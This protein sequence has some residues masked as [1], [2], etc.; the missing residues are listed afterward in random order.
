VSARE[1]GEASGNRCDEAE[2]DRGFSG[3]GGGFLGWGIGARI[4]PANDRA[5]GGGKE[6]GADRNLRGFSI[7]CLGD[8]RGVSG[9]DEGGGEIS[10]EEV[11]WDGWDKGASGDGADDG[12]FCLGVGEG[13]REFLCKEES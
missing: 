5:T 3:W 11:V 2:A 9:G 10:G 4:Y 1:N 12:G 13:G 7:C 6:S 8:F